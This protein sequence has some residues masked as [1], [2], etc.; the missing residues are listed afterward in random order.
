[1][2]GQSEQGDG[3]DVED[4]QG[5]VTPDHLLQICGVQHGEDTAERVHL[6]GDVLFS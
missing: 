4:R 6:H 3:A 5:D 1:M 2:T